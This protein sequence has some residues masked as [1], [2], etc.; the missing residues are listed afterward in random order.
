MESM[1]MLG[2]ERPDSLLTLTDT[3]PVLATRRLDP[4]RSANPGSVFGDDY[5]YLTAALL[6]AHAAP[7]RLK[8]SDVPP[9]F[10]RLFKTYCWLLLNHEEPP[11]GLPRSGR[12]HQARLA[13]LSIF[14]HYSKLKPFFEWLAMQPTR[15]LIALTAEDYDAYLRYLLDGPFSADKCKRCIEAVQVFWTYRDLLP[16]EG[17]LPILVPW[18]GANARELAGAPHKQSNEN[19]TVRIPEATMQPLLGWAIRFIEIFAQDIQVAYDEFRILSPRT[20]LARHDGRSP[21]LRRRGPQRSLRTDVNKLLDWY[22]QVGRPLPGRRNNAGE[23]EPDHWHFARQLDC[24]FGAMR[25]L[26]GWLT[27]N[28]AQR[29]LPLVDGAPLHDRV[30]GQLDGAPW[31]RTPIT[32]DECRPLVRHLNIAALIII[33]YLSG[34][35]LGEV[36]NLERH[37]AVH[38][39]DLHLDF[40]HG[41]WFKNARGPDG[42][43]LPEGAQREIPWT[44]V[45][46]VITAISIVESLHEEQMLFPVSLQRSRRERKLRGRENKARD[47]YYVARDIRAFIQWVNTYCDEHGRTDHIPPD[48]NGIP[49]T[50]TRFRRTLAWFIWHRPR[51]AV[52]AALQYGHVKVTITQG[53]AGSADSGFPDDLAYEEFLARNARILEDSGY[54]LEGEHVSGPAAGLYRTRVSKTTARFSG[55]VFVTKRQAHTALNSLD[56]QI[57]HGQAMT[58]VFDRAKAQCELLQISDDPRRTPDLDNCRVTCANI[59]R[60]DRDIEYVRRQL[61]VFQTEASDPLAP[62]PRRMRASTLANRTQKIVDM[63]EAQQFSSEDTPAH[64]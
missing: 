23:L 33:A 29:S 46:I 41:R 20:E 19:A 55:R 1:D 31:R 50:V 16:P 53:Y 7:V 42:S 39:D 49:I 51:G 8:F 64:D 62:E 14:G 11:P 45:P 59:A 32:Y 12:P 5:W 2:A 15:S 6:E 26:R 44:V 40:V 37:C 58:C 38:D 10:Q 13:I 54:L 4:Q 30:T 24:N 56:F 22:E 63:H 17:R 61:I 36:L 48:P 47:A 9:Q 60:T 43:K 34:M 18:N 21:A 52:A 3:T 27:S 57:Y 35:R 25:K 28:V